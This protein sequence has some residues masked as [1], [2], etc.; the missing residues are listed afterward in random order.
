MRNVSFDKCGCDCSDP[1]EI[2]GVI[3]NGRRY[4]DG[5]VAIETFNVAVNDL[6]NRIKNV[7]DVAAA[8]SERLINV[9]KSVSEIATEV[10]KNSA[11][12]DEMA[13]D[14]VEHSQWVGH[15]IEEIK[16]ELKV[17]PEVRSDINGLSGAIEKA[18]SRISAA[19]SEFEETTNSLSERIAKLES[20][21]DPLIV[22]NNFAATPKTLE[23]GS[24]ANIIVSWNLSR[25]ATTAVLNGINV[26]G[27]Q[28]YTDTGVSADR[29]YKL[30]VA[31]ELGREVKASTKVSFV[32]NVFWG[33]SAET[34]ITETLVETLANSV[35]SNSKARSLQVKPAGQYIYY[36][37]PKRLGTAI[38]KQGYFEGGFEDPVTIRITNG[39]SYAEDYYVYRSTQNLTAT[40]DLTIS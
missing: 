30:T 2:S 33:V 34:A 16:D 7:G 4:D 27:Q 10:R 3:R 6:N 40:I 18:N 5:N 36:A 31:D 24:T 35:L 37:Y 14:I 8:A 15:E 19:T 32:N 20:G 28:Q 13:D 9:E 1:L 17:L 23:I 21:T 25:A 26:L 12:I 29:E 11:D 38:F 39:S 22:I